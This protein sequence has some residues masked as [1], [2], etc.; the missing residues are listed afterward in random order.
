M[1]NV[2]VDPAPRPSS[3]NV[4]K[5]VAAKW[6]ITTRPAPEAGWLELTIARDGRKEVIAEVPAFPVVR[7]RELITRELRRLRPGLNDTI[8]LPAIYLL[9]ED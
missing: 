3:E 7:A 9:L 5:H 2:P 8:E 1:Y 6:V 4:N